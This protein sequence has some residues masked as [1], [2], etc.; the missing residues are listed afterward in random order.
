MFRKVIL[1][2]SCF[3]LFFFSTASF[4]YA[5]EEFTLEDLKGTT[6][7]WTQQLE[8]FSEIMTNLLVSEFQEATGIIVDV[9]QISGGEI[10]G[11]LTTEFIAET[12][13]YSV[14]RI[15]PHEGAHM[16]PAGWLANIAPYLEQAEQQGRAPFFDA[17]DIIEAA[18]KSH[19]LTV[20]P[21]EGLY[22]IPLNVNMRLLAYRKS[23][24]EDP[25]YKKEFKE[26]YGYDLKLPETVDELLDI[27]NFFTRDT[28]GDGNIDLYGF[29]VPQSSGTH[30]WLWSYDLILTF[31]GQL[32]CPEEEK[33]LVSEYREEIIRAF[34]WGKELQATHLPGTRAWDDGDNFSAFSEGRA[35]MIHMWYTW[36]PRLWDEEYTQF[37]G[38][39]GILTM[40]RDPATGFT[41]G[42]TSGGG[43]SLV[44]NSFSSSKQKAAAVEFGRWILS[45]ENSIKLAKA[46]AITPRHSVF[47]GIME[48]DEILAENPYFKEVIPVYFKALEHQIQPRPATVAVGAVLDELSYIWELIIEN[49]LSIEEAVDELDMRIQE[50]LALYN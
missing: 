18:W 9:E 32:V 28:T 1:L 21:Y 14:M 48:D 20:L 36:T 2:I 3:A 45:K 27:A 24:F 43:G 5:I 49:V 17:D 31:G 23:L 44:I 15:S 7:R 11:K 50:T 6:I 13:Y 16:I 10:M 41:T 33:S 38:D 30:C 22:A 8:P 37:A 29:N 42:R 39:F 19:G 4:S 25:D 40:V 12:D 46:G 26:E 47:D 35:A 34:E